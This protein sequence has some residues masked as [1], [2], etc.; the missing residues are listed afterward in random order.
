MGA[1]S[2]AV[3]RKAEPRGDASG[4]YGKQERLGGARAEFAANLGR[5]VSEITAC[6]TRAEQ[7]PATARP[8]DDL[9]RRLHSLSAGARL[10][11]FGTLAEE[12]AT[13]EARIGVAAGRG[14]LDPEDAA[15]LRASLDQVP[16]LA[17]S[18][19]AVRSTV[20]TTRGAPP[21]S[22]SGTSLAA[23][24]DMPPPMPPLELDL[25][26]SASPPSSPS[27]TPAPAS[28]K[29]A[30]ADD[31]SDLTTEP[32]GA[33]PLSVLIVGPAQMADALLEEE[34]G[35]RF[36]IER[37][38]ETT[39]AIGLARTIVPDL[40]IVDTD[41][42]GARELV[43][44]LAADPITED[45]A[46][47]AIGPWTRPDEAASYVAL[48]VARALP[49]P[50]SPAALRRACVEA[51]ATYVR[52]ENRREPLGEATLD[53]LGARLAD[54]LRRGLCDAAGP[55]SRSARVDFGEG[56]DVL[57]ALWGAVARIRDIATIRSQGAVRWNSG[58]PEGALPF[59]P[60][61][62]ERDG[63]AGQSRV[64]PF[65]G[66]VRGDTRG[67][68]GAGLDGL[69]IVIADDDPAVTWFLADVLGAAGATVHEAH[70]GARA[71]ELAY[72]VAPDLVIS[73]VLMPE[74]DGFALCRTLKRDLALRDVPV[75]LLSWKEDLLQRVRELGA[76]ADGYL[77]KQASAGAIVQ[78]VREV[79]AP[80][81]RVAER[82]A[83]R[84]EVRGRLDGLTTRTLLSMVC[85]GRPS[86]TLAVRDASYLYEVEVRDGRPV[87]ATRTAPDG[88]FQRGPAVLAALLGV[89]AGRFAVSP[90]P[91]PLPGR[92]AH[93]F[94]AD[95]TGS[96]SEQLLPPI[97][98]ARAAQ[99]LLSGE[100]LML[101]ERVV[102]DEERLLACAG[103]TPEPARVLLQRLARG[104]SPRALVLSGRASPRFL[105]DVLCDAAARGAIAAI[106][107]SERCDVLPAAIAREADVLRGVRRPLPPPAEIPILGLAQDASDD[108]PERE[109]LVAEASETPASPTYLDAVPTDETSTAIAATGSV[110]DVDLDD[111]DVLIAA[112]AAPDQG[113]QSA[114]PTLLSPPPPEAPRRPVQGPITTLGSLS[115]P[116]VESKIAELSAAPSFTDSPSVPGIE[117]PARHRS[118]PPRAPSSA[119]NISPSRRVLR[120]SAYAPEAPTPVDTKP[121]ATTRPTMWLLFAAAGIVFAVGAR[122]SRERS[123]VEPA[124][125]SP[126]PPPAHIAPPAP[127]PSALIETA[128]A[129]PAAAAPAPQER[130][131]GESAEHPVLPQDLPLRAEDKVPSGQ[132]M[133]EIV[134]GVSDTIYVDHRLIG[135][136]PIL[137]LPL[138]PKAAPYEIRVKLRGEERVRFAVVKEGR[139]TRLR[140]APPW[141]R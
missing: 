49:T 58:G 45:A 85:T 56:S 102:I 127:A 135:S 7:Q 1:G 88:T 141:A 70:D 97:A 83:T 74:I 138:A 57:A 125:L 3:E 133:L 86:S 47:L 90:A 61:L 126:S 63:E 44:A 137:K 34:G 14:V 32:H 27:S 123:L 124:A 17:W 12:L 140:I 76:E 68:K 113:V 132:G 16:A 82:L 98:S 50:V 79:M 121:P 41:R 139:L 96:L 69:V 72:Q 5:R 48:G 108:E 93:S 38:E 15:A 104:M 136:G 36:E 109:E 43:E 53:Q 129:S 120:P 4:V 51:A 119:D 101:A 115:P 26:T 65:S 35:A 87:R 33:L 23:T 78:R 9:R 122:L 100:A 59:A 28:S 103:V 131:E 20:M 89:G 116:P 31:S 40:V 118:T 67:A 105:E 112:P 18:G 71:I 64:R 2:G 52:R 111:V 80:R 94:R 21:D 114:R 128:P 84:G 30:P 99:R 10:L 60:W 39:D 107:D 92:R 54:E 6:L 130:P 24:V 66:E 37:T 95:L 91:E 19:A 134:A 62:G 42:P 117:T 55:K 106:L 77:R 8:L 22:A 46:I 110:M 29:P 25:G 75:I 11:R 81:R 73:D 13:M